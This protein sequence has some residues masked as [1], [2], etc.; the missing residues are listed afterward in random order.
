MRTKKRNHLLVV[1]PITQTF[2]ASGSPSEVLPRVAAA[3][4]HLG[5]SILESGA[6]WLK[7]RTG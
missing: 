2:T 1:A 4:T 5:W 3:V 6:T 7:C